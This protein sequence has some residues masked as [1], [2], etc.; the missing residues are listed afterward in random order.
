[1]KQKFES[2]DQLRLFLEWKVPLGI[3]PLRPAK[4]MFV[5]PFSS[6]NAKEV[7][8]DSLVDALWDDV[9]IEKFKQMKS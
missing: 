8:L 1:M 2:K 5:D 4:T 9:K 7:V 6:R 3:K